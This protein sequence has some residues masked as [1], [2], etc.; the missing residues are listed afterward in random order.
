MGYYQEWPPYVPVA[1]RRRK[2]AAAMKARAKKG[3]AVDPVVIE[4]RTIARSAWGKRW[5]ELLEGQSYF[6][7]RI[8]RG[9]TYARNGSVVHLAVAK[10]ELTA[11]VSGSEL[12]DVRITVAPLSEAKWK[13]VRRQC[14]GQVGSAL[15]LLQGKLSD[16]VMDLI[17]RPETGLIPLAS[18]VKFK[19]SCPDA[20]TLCKHC[21]AVLYGVGARLDTKPELLFTLRGVSHLDLVDEASVKLT[22]QPAAGSALAADDATLS[23][24]FGI[25]LGGAPAAKAPPAMAKAVT[26]APKKKPA[27]ARSVEPAAAKAVAVEHTLAELRA[28]GHTPARVKAMLKDGSLERAS[29]GWYRFTR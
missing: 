8:E 4:G 5:C 21:A 26:K 17:A 1:E 24:I 27:A 20:A 12:Y 29:F 28:M 14:A 22:A 6:A 11:V 19:C 2:A 13:A 18:E 16:K 3:L 15:A 23:S 10:G 25:D 7:S 9:R